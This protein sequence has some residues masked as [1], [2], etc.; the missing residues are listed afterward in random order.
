MSAEIIAFDLET[1]GLSPLKGHRVIEIGAVRIKAG[2]QEATFH[3]LIDA[4][5]PIRKRASR[6][7]GITNDM[8]REGLSP[9]EAFRNFREFC[10]NAA[11]VAHNAPFDRL[12]LQYEYSRFGWGLRNEILCTLDMCRQ[13]VPDLPN[14]RL[15][16]VARH[17]LSDPLLESHELHRALYDARLTARIWLALEMGNAG[18]N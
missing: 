2:R 10:S 11:L 15:A 5:R 13:K 16:T 4:G 7:N 14:Y 8:L 1:T 17:L 18:S 12:F 3:T 9:G 6:I